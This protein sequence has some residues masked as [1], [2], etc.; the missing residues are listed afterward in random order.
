MTIVEVIN[1]GKKVYKGEGASEDK[2][3]EAE[4]H[5]NLNFS[6]EYREYLRQFGSVMI[7]GHELTGISAATSDLV[8]KVTDRE[9]KNFSIIP[10]DFYVIE[11][12]GFDGIVIWQSGNGVIYK[13]FSDGTYR[14]CADSLAD[15]L[16]KQKAM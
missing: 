12:T 10:S 3:A 5:L 16:T 6:E 8:T 15:Y 4:K 1:N 9:K 7:D 13:S 2:I 11:I 14:R